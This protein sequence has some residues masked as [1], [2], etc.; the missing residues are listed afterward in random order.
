ME[1]LTLAR[2]KSGSEMM[3]RGALAILQALADNSVDESA[4]AGVF[5]L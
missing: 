5:G 2:L 3:C 4:L 1:D